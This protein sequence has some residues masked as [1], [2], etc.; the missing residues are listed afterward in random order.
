MKAAVVMPAHL[1]VDSCVGLAADVD[2]FPRPTSVFG[3]KTPVLSC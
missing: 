2:R 3:M 1:L